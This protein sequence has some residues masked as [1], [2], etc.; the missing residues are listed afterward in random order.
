MINIPLLMTENDSP[1]FYFTSAYSALGDVYNLSQ[2]DHATNL[3]GAL[4]CKN[5]DIYGKD[6]AATPLEIAATCAVLSFAPFYIPI[7]PSTRRGRTLLVLYITDEIDATGFLQVW[8]L[9]DRER[10]WIPPL[11]Q[12]L[13]CSTLGSRRKGFVCCVLV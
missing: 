9:G 10:I 13:G 11:G 3:A 6:G 5:G 4:R 12:T 2:V 1:V 8:V 7:R